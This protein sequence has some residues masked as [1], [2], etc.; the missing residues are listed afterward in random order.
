VP[1]SDFPGRPDEPPLPLKTRL[2]ARTSLLSVDHIIDSNVTAF[3]PNGWS[4]ETHKT[5]GAVPWRPATADLWLGP[6]QRARPVKGNILCKRLEALPVLNATF[7]DYLFEH[8]ELIPETWEGL[9][10]FFWGTIYRRHTGLAVR[11]LYLK[12]GILNIGSR[13][14]KLRWS[15]YNPAAVLNAA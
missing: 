7:L 12:D 11:G 3:V 10:V 1:Q 6:V 8:P 5:Y 4:I 15:L 2:L 13:L 14:L 9:Y